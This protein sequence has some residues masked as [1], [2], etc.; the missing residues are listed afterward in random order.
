M[1]LAILGGRGGAEEPVAGERRVAL[2]EISSVRSAWSVRKPGRGSCGLAETDPSTSS[3]PSTAAKPLFAGCQQA[4]GA[5][6]GVE[7]MLQRPAGP[8]RGQGRHTALEARSGDHRG[9][10]WLPSADNLAYLCRAGGHYVAGMRMRDGG[11]LA[12]QAL[13]PQGRCQQV[14]DNLRVKEVRVEGARD[15]RFIICHNPEQADRDKSQRE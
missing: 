8:G 5:E 4:G 14:R 10:P 15:T 3:P 7:L 6:Q 12:E 11:E 1:S 2:V 13:A 9:R